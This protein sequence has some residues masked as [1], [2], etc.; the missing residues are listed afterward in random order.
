MR[1]A[2]NSFAGFILRPA[3][4]LAMLTILTVSAFASPAIP[5]PIITFLSPVS[6]NPGGDDLTLTVNGA[7][8]VN[9]VSVANW[10][11]NALA[12]TFVNSTKL[13]ERFRRR[14]PRALERA[15]SRW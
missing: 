14:R 15:G 11:G 8:F 5:V 12:T 4:L 9:G 10:K 7:N 2:R 1:S 3:F 6:T 13:T